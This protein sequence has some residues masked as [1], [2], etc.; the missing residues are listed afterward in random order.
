[1]NFG[2][3]SRPNREDLLGSTMLHENVLVDEV[4]DNVSAV[5]TV[6][7]VPTARLVVESMTTTIH[8]LMFTITGTRPMESICHLENMWPV[9]SECTGYSECTGACLRVTP[10]A[11]LSW[12]SRQVEIALA[13]SATASYE[14]N[15]RYLVVLDVRAVCA[16]WQSRRLARLVASILQ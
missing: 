15:R 16:L 4:R 12:H 6:V 3:E 2:R 1:M 9:G 14:N 7:S 10:P 13:K 11:G 8:V 5:V